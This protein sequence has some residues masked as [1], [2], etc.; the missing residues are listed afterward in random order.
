MAKKIVIGIGTGRCGTKSLAAL[1]DGCRGCEVTHEFGSPL[2]WHVDKQAFENKKKL[3]ETYDGKV[4]GDVALYHLNYA[5]MWGAKIIHIYRDK[6]KAVDSLIDK[7]EG[8]GHW[9]N[10]ATP[11]DKAFPT[12]A[13]K[14]KKEAVSAYYDLYI[15]LVEDIKSPIL[16]INIEELNTREGQKKIFDFAEIEENDRVYKTYRLNKIYENRS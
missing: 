6:K 7:T 8:K 12:L 14:E 16:N 4:I 5:D 2:P 1:L 13:W 3:I 11:W 10:D 9:R 15:S